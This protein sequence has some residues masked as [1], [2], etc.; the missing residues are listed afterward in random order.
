MDQILCS[1]PLRLLAV[2]AVGMP[3]SVKQEAQE[4]GRERLEVRILAAQGIRQ[5]QHQVKVITVVHLPLLHLHM[6]VVAVEELMLLA[7]MALEVLVVM[8]AT[9]PHHL[10]LDRL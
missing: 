4:V 5:V 7:V 1:L 8:A 10:F 9:E 6:A 3:Q 2:V